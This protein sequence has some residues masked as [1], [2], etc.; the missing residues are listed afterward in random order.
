MDIIVEE[1]GFANMDAFRNALP[2][3]LRNEEMIK[4]AKDMA[5]IAQMAVDNKRMV[6][7]KT[8]EFLHSVPADASTPEGATAL[9]SVY[10]KLGWPGA[11]GKYEVTR[12][13]KIDGIDYSE[14]QEAKFLEFAKENRMSGKLVNGLIAMQN[15]MQK[16]MLAKSLEEAKAADTQLR[17][18]WGPDY[19]KN[20]A[21]TKAIL[22][23][24]APAHIV[25]LF[26][27]T[28]LGS[29][30]IFTQWIHD[31]MKGTIEKGAVGHGEGGQ[32]GITKDE[33]TKQIA[34]NYSSKEF[35]DVYGNPRDPGYKAKRE[36]MYQLHKTVSGTEV[37]A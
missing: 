3:E 37:V 30:A 18:D 7:Q 25:K 17:A 15:E 31:N 32:G 9:D 28:E 26:N 21:E 16:G 4:N 6:G 23:K 5:G 11:E 34:A 24:T 29:D 13:D 22:E 2:E 1:G 10:T 35:M 19:D 12:P 27:E 33:A 14:E 20:K 8:E 36:E